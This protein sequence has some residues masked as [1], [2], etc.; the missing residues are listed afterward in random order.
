MLSQGLTRLNVHTNQILV[1]IFERTD[2]FFVF[3]GYKAQFHQSRTR[4]NACV[5][6]VC[7]YVCVCVW[8]GGGGGGQMSC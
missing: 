5:F 6:R 2:I 3:S 4:L 7:V 8:G 1:H